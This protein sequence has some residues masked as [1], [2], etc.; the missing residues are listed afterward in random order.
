MHLFHVTH[1]DQSIGYHL[2]PQ[3]D[4]NT[5]REVVLGAYAPGATAEWLG[6]CSLTD[7]G[8]VWDWMKE[9]RRQDEKRRSERGER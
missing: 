4:L 9:L 6:T 3:P 8:E 2:G 7:P 1:K 5:A